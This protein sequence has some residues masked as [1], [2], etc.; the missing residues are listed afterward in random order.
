[1]ITLMIIKIFASKIKSRLQI[2]CYEQLKSYFFQID[3]APIKV[4]SD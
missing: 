3:L 4:W 2:K 1:M